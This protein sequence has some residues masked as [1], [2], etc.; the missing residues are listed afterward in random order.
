[1][2]IFN[3]QKFLKKMHFKFKHNFTY[4]INSMFIS[5]RKVRNTDEHKNKNDLL[6][7]DPG[8]ITVNMVE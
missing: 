2:L 5:I 3:K 8:I 4:H 6:L 1:M 7:D